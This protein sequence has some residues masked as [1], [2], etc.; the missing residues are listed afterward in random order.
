M[1]IDDTIN[2]GKDS[3]LAQ[4]YD[5]DM[6]VSFNGSPL[7]NE[8]KNELLTYDG[9]ETVEEYTTLTANLNAEDRSVSSAIYG[10]RKDSLFFKFDDE[11]EGGNWVENGV[12]LTQSKADDLGVKL[13]DTITFDINGTIYRKEVV[14]IFYAFFVNGAYLYVESEPELFTY[15]S[16]AWINVKNDEDPNLIKE[17]ILN[18]SKIVYTCLKPLNFE[19]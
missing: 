1:G 13:G 7:I 19:L 17:N 12:A 11:L 15:S 2:Y 5:S 18:N 8:A 10:I 9:I 14:Y 6:S 16:A 4:F 3:D